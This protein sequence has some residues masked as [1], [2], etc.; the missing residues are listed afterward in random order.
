VE[1]I[2]KKITWMTR[3]VQIIAHLPI[4]KT[5]KKKEKK[6]PKR[7]NLIFCYETKCIFNNSLKPKQDKSSITTTSQN[8]Y[9]FKRM[10]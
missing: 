2:E 3:K 9:K 10:L 5:P 8:S 1:K 6:T 7:N 4:K